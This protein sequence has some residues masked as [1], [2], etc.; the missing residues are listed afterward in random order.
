MERNDILTTIE[1]MKLIVREDAW[2]TITYFLMHFSFEC[3]KKGNIQ[4]TPEQINQTI[5]TMPAEKNSRR[6]SL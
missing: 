1:E 6:E 5:I 2:E 4:H 3:Y